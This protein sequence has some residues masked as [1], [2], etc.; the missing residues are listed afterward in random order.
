ML[1]SALLA[2]AAVLLPALAAGTARA[3]GTSAFGA[4]DAGQLRGYT[5]SPA[6]LYIPTG[7]PGARPAAAVPAPQRPKAP[8]CGR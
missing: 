8:A 4:A 3:D 6:Q 5:A 1:K 7:G 2:V